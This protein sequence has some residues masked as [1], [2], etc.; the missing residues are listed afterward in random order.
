MAEFVLKING[1]AMPSPTSYQWDLEDQSDPDAQR[2]EAGVMNKKRKGQVRAL[3]FAWSMLTTAEASKVLTAVQP[4]YFD[5]TFLC[6]L[7]G[8][9][10]TSNFY[11]GNRTAACFNQAEDRWE[12]VSFKF[13]EREMKQV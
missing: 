3:S 13:V 4:E 10:D 2:T 5:V 1:V 7:K 12:N 11:V 6:P 9:A 8:G